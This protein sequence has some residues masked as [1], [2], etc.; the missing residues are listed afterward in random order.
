MLTDPVLHQLVNDRRRSLGRTAPRRSVVDRTPD[1]ADV[2]AHRVA[3]DG[4]AGHEALV[5][6][7]ARHARRAGAPDVLTSVLADRRQPVVA[8][9]RAL[10]KVLAWL[11][12]PGRAVSV[13]DAA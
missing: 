5:A 9:E 3:A 7:V 2:A 11:A 13:D 1:W 12:R 8:R 6:D 10:G 4:V